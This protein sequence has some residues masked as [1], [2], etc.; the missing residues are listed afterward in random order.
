MSTIIKVRKRDAE[1]REDL[2]SEH[3][4][5]PRKHGKERRFTGPSLAITMPGLS[6]RVRCGASLF[7]SKAPCNPPEGGS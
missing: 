6:A 3:D 1:W 7:R 5:V 4:R 2:A